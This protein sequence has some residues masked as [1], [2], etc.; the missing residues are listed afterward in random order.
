MSIAERKTREKQRRVNAILDAAEEVFFGD[1]GM[2]A[3]MDE[4]ANLAEVSKGTLYLYFKNKESLFLGIGVRANK[5]AVE[6]LQMGIDRGDRGIEKVLEAVSAYHEFS[7]KYPHYFRLKSLSDEI[8]NRPF[9]DGSDDPQMDMC[10]ESGMACGRALA[11]A[12]ED[13]IKDG[14]IRSDIDPMI[15]T[16]LIWSQSNGVIKLIESKG[17]HLKDRLGIDP[18]NLFKAFQKFVY[19]S[20]AA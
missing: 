5:V 8:T 12:I 16:L 18:D 2:S 11:G 7:V 9:R 15:T 20:I 6:F 10:M 1:D 3:S 17:M 13:G 14:S 4:V 19:R